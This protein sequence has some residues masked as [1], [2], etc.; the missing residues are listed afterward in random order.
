MN[1]MTEGTANLND[2]I[3]KF[4]YSLVQHG[5]YNDRIYLLKLSVSDVPDILSTLE[6]VRRNNGY[7]KIFAKVPAQ[8]AVSFITSG[9]AIEAFIPDFFSDGSDA[10]FLSKFY[11]QKRAELPSEEL[12]KLQDVLDNPRKNEKK[13]LAPKFNIR[14]AG[15]KDLNDMADLYSGVFK[16]YPFPIFDPQYLSDT[17][18]SH[19]EY[20]SV[21]HDNTLVALSSAEMD[22]ENK[23]AELTDFAVLPEY[24]GNQLAYFLL[25]E[26]ERAMIQK[27]IKSLYT[28][29]RLKS[30]GMNIT[31]LKS[32]YKYSGTLVNNTNI[33]GGLESMNVLYKHV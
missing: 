17:M 27:G 2:K 8:Y 28:I 14:A 19:I 18:K 29:A 33:S 32:G 13:K 25:F 26:M 30:I 7:S 24:R 16:T 20:Y 23:N 11:S 31:F 6:E 12:N 4:G 10:F 22:T 15:E 21:W 9:Y 1:D 5:K 3:E